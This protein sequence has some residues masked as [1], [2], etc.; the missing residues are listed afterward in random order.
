MA[1]GPTLRNDLALSQTQYGLLITSFYIGQVALAIPSGRLVDRIGVRKGL[2]L[3]VFTSIASLGGL[4]FVAGFPAAAF[5]LFALGIAAALVNPATAK[6]V[7][8]WIPERRRAFAMS[9]KQTGVPIGALIAAAAAYVAVGRGRAEV[10]T[11]LAALLLLG[12]V[13]L[14]ALPADKGRPHGSAEIKLSAL[15]RNKQLLTIGLCNGLFNVA[16]VG[17]WVSVAIFAAGLG[18][19]AEVG[20]ICFAVL[21][22]AS[23]IGRVALGFAAHRVG[24]KYLW[25]LIVWV[26]GVGSVALLALAFATNVYFLIGT[27]TILGLTIGS[28]P[29]IL[30]TMALNS[31]PQ[32]GSASAI[33]VNM[34]LV[35]LGGM[36]APVLVGAIVD[37]GG[38]FEQAFVLLAG[39]A[40]CGCY[41]LFRAR[42]QLIK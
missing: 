19:G 31:V 40:A 1:S 28:Y 41:L 32:W 23:A 35:L 14:L 10:F 17:L 20:A 5:I 16:Q 13:V 34:V 11:A 3:A 24:R 38:G 39:V 15:L 4:A 33:G 30:Q 7:F 42:N 21:H 26:C 22:S 37:F 18:D 27:L 8:D 29:G 12:S 6:G 9:V 2:T 25:L 36:V